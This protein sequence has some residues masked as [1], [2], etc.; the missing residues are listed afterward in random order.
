MK[1][2]DPLFS[3]DFLDELEKEINQQY[4]WEKPDQPEEEMNK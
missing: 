2:S 4:G 3:D 1:E